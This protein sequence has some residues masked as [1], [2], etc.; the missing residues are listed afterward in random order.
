MS[1]SIILIVLVGAFLGVQGLLKIVENEHSVR[2]R[3]QFRLPQ[4]TWARVG[5]VEMIIAMFAAAGMFY[6]P[7]AVVSALLAAGLM[8]SALYAHFE[9]FD[10][11]IKAV[12]AIIVLAASAFALGL[13]AYN[14]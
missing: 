14:G 8:I 1:I 7:F 5:Q 6:T 13:W 4:K 12:P 9:N 2:M 11:A 3:D 10:D